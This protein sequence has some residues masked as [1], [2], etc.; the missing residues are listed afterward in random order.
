MRLTRTR[1]DVVTLVASRWELAPLAAAA[2]MQLEL[3]RA[4]AHAPASAGDLLAK[5]LA[6]YDAACARLARQE[7][8]SPA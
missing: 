8:S 3:M 1:A 4:D 2:R 7:T 5:V 6:D